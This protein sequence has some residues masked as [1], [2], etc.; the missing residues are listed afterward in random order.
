MTALLRSKAAL[1][2]TRAVRSSQSAQWHSA[3]VATAAT[4]CESA[5]TSA[6]EPRGEAGSRVTHKD[7]V[8]TKAIPTPIVTAMALAE[9]LEDRKGTGITRSLASRPDWLHDAARLIGLTT[10]DLSRAKEYLKQLRERAARAF[11]ESPEPEEPYPEHR[12]RQRIMTRQLDRMLAS[13]LQ[14]GKFKEVESIA[15][16]YDEAFPEF[17]TNAKHWSVICGHYAVALNKQKR[18]DE[19]IEKLFLS[20]FLSTDDDVVHTKPEFSNR[21]ILTPLIAEAAF[22]ACNHVNDA[23]TALK[24]LHVVRERK[25]PLHHAAY[26]H[27]LG[28]ILKD[29]KYV[30]FDLVVDLSTEIVDG[31][32]REIP[33]AVL[34]T[35]IRLAAERGELH[36]VMPLYQLRPNASMNPYTEFRFDICLQ[37]LWKMR[38]TDEMLRVLSDF[39]ELR[40]V[41]FEKK[42]QICKG[43]L[44]KSL[45]ERKEASRMQ[46]MNATHGL[47][48]LMQK[49]RI[50]MSNK[51]IPPLLQTLIEDDHL[52]T[53]DEFLSFFAKYPDVMHWN[54]AVVCELIIT[55]V[56]AKHMTLVDDLLVHTLD[57]NIPIKYVALEVVVASYYRHGM[58]E[59]LDKAAS[60]IGALRLNKRIPLGIA[61]TEIG[62]ACNLRLRRYEDVANLFEDFAHMDGERK[63]IVSR[64]PMLVKARSAYLKLRRYDEA[65]AMYKLLNEYHTEHPTNDNNKDE[66]PLIDDDYGTPDAVQR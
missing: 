18:F 19:V 63:R 35:I 40:H 51:C 4:E 17:A 49:H 38:N 7:H 24:L 54:A 62:M 41:S 23:E 22:L 36:R 44:R 9:Q 52:E 33:P 13:L 2:V 39:L 42:Q 50:A 66:V 48:D 14:A 32:K 43:L 20:G 29:E 26:F 5:V 15:F 12:R 58:L 34:P 57:N 37:T 1:G 60:I 6:E 31:L 3:A 64:K 25:I 53:F 30:D 59:S 46:A 55:A 28:A 27:L 47:L 56:R 10:D 16:L 8:L 61:L 65:D 21:I 45:A 11:D